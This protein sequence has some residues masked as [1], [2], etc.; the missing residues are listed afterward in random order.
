MRSVNEEISAAGRG[1][2]HKFTTRRGNLISISRAKSEINER[3]PR[4]Y[5][6]Q[7]KVPDN[8]TNESEESAA[9]VES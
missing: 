5:H 2:S 9:D 6:D 7:N 4:E 3:K 1:P 8:T